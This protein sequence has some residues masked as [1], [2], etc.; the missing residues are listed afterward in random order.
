MQ[1]TFFIPS[2][3]DEQRSNRFEEKQNWKNLPGN[4]YTP[5]EL[6]LMSQDLSDFKFVR[7]TPLVYVA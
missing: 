7:R 6:K 4:R 1:E 2:E 5:D 3:T